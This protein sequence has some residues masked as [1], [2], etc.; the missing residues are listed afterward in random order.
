LVAVGEFDSRSFERTSE[1]SD[2]R[3]V[4]YQYSRLGFETFNRR[5]GDRRRI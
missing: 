4:R 5:E 3:C 2:R 1:R